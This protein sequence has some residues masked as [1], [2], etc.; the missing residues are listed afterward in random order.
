MPPIIIVTGLAILGLCTTPLCYLSLD[1]LISS[2]VSSVLHCY[3]WFPAFPSAADKE[4]S[5]EIV[6]G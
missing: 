4:S 6:R 2:I 1:W 3:F 5:Q